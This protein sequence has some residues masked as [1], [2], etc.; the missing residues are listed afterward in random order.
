MKKNMK[1]NMA[2]DMT[3]GSPLRLLI[4]FSIPILLGTLFQ[5]LYNMVDTVIVGRYL[6][7]QALSAVGATGSVTYLVTGFCTGLCNGFAIPISQQFGAKDYRKMRKY[8]MNCI[9]LSILCAVIMTI[10][11]VGF[12]WNILELMK[13]PE[14]IIHGSFSYLIVI[15]A[16]LPFTFLY[17]MT[18]G[19]LRAIGDSKRPFYFLLVATGI[20]IILDLLFIIVLGMGVAGAAYATIIAQAFSGIACLIYTKKKYEILHIKA[21][22]KNVEKTCVFELCKMG[23]P[24]GL[25][26]C[27]TGIGTVIVQSAVNLLGMSYVASFTA[28][29]RLKQLSVM[30]YIAM[31]SAIAT[32][33]SQNYGAGKIDRVK[34][35]VKAGLLIYGAITLIVLPILTLGSDKAALIFVEAAEVEVLKNVDLYYKCCGPFYIVLIFLDCYRSVLQGLGHSSISMIAGVCELAGRG[36]ISLF[37]VPVVG[38]IGICFADSI[39]WVVAAVWVMSMYYVIMRKISTG[40]MKKEIHL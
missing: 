26:T 34:K 15:F 22:E 4:H 9:Y 36:I 16:G 14:E 32:F 17:N 11:T 39:A 2:K 20:N 37:V 28:V 7:I 19:V 8:L 5:Q 24:L 40:K 38:Y 6:G 33:T 13:M 18:A 1:K 35:G 23:I 12:C 25:L 10:S 30:P 29:S 3:E 21:D 31:D 27:V